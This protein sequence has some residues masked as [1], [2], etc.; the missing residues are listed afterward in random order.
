MAGDSN[1]GTYVAV[2]A[3]VVLSLSAIGVFYLLKSKGVLSCCS[4]SRR[5]KVRAIFGIIL[6]D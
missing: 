2:T 5:G 1:A 3:T 4:S 6:G